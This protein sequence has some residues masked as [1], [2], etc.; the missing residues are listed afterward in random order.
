MH[1]LWRISLCSDADSRND[2]IGEE[3]ERQERIEGTR[4]EGTPGMRGTLTRFAGGG[5]EE[6]EEELLDGAAFFLGGISSASPTS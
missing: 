1:P 6:E 2:V 4:V 5:A 3:D